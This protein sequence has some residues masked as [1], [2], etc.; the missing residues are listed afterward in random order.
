MSD[1]RVAVVV[2]GQSLKTVQSY[3]PSNY[4]AYENDSGQILICGNDVAG[5]TLDG[6]VLPRLSSGLIAAKEIK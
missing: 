1:L 6:Y 4:K 5:W 3:M 2:S